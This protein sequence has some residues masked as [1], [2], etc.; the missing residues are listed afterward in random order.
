MTDSKDEL[1]LPRMYLKKEFE[2]FFIVVSILPAVDSSQ[3]G[4]SLQKFSANRVTRLLKH[5]VV[6][7]SNFMM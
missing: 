4:L 5:F 2:I 6:S 1:K 7:K 3:N